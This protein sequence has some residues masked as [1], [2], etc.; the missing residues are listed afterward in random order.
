MADEPKK[1]YLDM[2]ED[3]L[4]K[5]K[6]YRRQLRFKIKQIIEE[7]TGQELSDE[8]NYMLIIKTLPQDKQQ[9]IYG[10]IMLAQS[11]PNIGEEKK[12]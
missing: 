10:R 5:M 11:F 3:Q 4:Q 2:V 1:N 12:E 6:E 7:E 9:N 8:G